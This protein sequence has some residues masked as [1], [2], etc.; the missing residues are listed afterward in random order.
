MATLYAEI[1]DLF[2]LESRCKEISEKKLECENLVENPSWNIPNYQRLYSWENPNFNKFIETMEEIADIE[3]QCPTKFFGQIILHINESGNYDIVD[4]QQRLTTFMILAVVILQSNRK[5]APKTEKVLEEF[6]YSI[7]EKKQMKFV[8][9]LKNI[10]VIKAYVFLEEPDK[11]VETSVHS[12]YKTYKK[13]NDLK[14]YR[15][16]LKTY[17]KGSKE[18]RKEHYKSVVEG[19][20]K[21]STWYEELEDLKS[22]ELVK[23]LTEGYIK[24]SVMLSSSFEMAYDSFMTLN[25]EGRS[26]TDYDLIKSFFIGEISNTTDHTDIIKEWNQRIEGGNLNNKTLLDILET[27][28]KTKYNSLIREYNIILTKKIDMLSLLKCCRRSN[29]D[30]LYGIF[31]DYSRY[32]TYY[33]QMKSG[34]FSSTLKTDSKK[35][36]KYNRSVESLVNMNYVPFIPLMFDII[37]SNELVEPLQVE[38]AINFAKY[39]PFIYVTLFNQKP[40][41]LTSIMDEYLMK[42]EMGTNEKIDEMYGQF[43]KLLPRIDFKKQVIYELELDS[44]KQYISKDLLLLLEPNISYNDKY[45]HHLEH[46]YPQKPKKGEWI[47]FEENEKLKWNIGNQVIMPDYLN[48]KMGNKE[49]S[50][51]RQDILDKYKTEEDKRT[52][53]AYSGAST[54]IE[55]YVIPNEEFTPIHVRKRAEEYADKLEEI[56]IEMGLLCKDLNEIKTK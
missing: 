6:V 3:K 8:H 31:E 41:K 34:N 30:L 33:L 54:F 2:E 4:G 36:Q 1:V 28:L 23:N 12:M 53:S 15:N 43:T 14:N 17:Y 11:K 52:L 38:R 42:P 39:A 20:D 35:Y 49:Y 18:Y 46:I 21:I 13:D 19:F 48:L 16:S 7:P 45:I 5:Q 50:G 44:K 29:G 22:T 10:D 32:V 24:I 47:A 25:S 26:L 27:L 9:Q 55:N 51:K 37:S 56:F 40:N